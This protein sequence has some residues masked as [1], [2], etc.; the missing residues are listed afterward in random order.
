MM[1]SLFG[2][3]KNS[4]VRYALGIFALMGLLGLAACQRDPFY[5]TQDPQYQPT[6]EV[7]TIRMDTLL[8]RRS[9]AT[10]LLTVYNQ[11]NQNLLLNKVYTQKGTQEGYRINVDGRAGE[12]HTDILLPAR[13]SLYIR[14]EAT[15]P[16][17]ESDLPT[18]VRDSLLI[19]CQG[20]RSGALLLGFRQNVTELKGERITQNRTLTAQRPYRVIDSLIVEEGATLT[21]EAGV[22]LLVDARAYIRVRGTLLSQGTPQKRVT[23]EGSRLDRLLPTVSY[24]WIP[25]QWQGMV[26]D[27]PSQNNRWSYTTIRNAQQGVY[28]YPD[29]REKSAKLSMKGCVI[30][31]MNRT[32]LHTEGGVF[33]LENCELSNSG[34]ALVDCTAGELSLH[35][36]TLVN[37]FPWS[38][39]TQ[40]AV[41]LRE[42][43]PM[44]TR[45]QAT[46]TIVDGNRTQAA[47]PKSIGGEE[48]SIP[49]SLQEKVLWQE[50]YLRSQIE[51]HPR[52]FVSCRR[53][54]GTARDRYRL[55][56]WDSKNEKSSFLYDFRPLLKT[57]LAEW[58]LLNQASATDLLGVVRAPSPTI[59]AYQAV[60]PQVPAP[61]WILPL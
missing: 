49:E 46:R 8:S 59:G 25:G 43:A 48:L 58:V 61:W 54:E 2:S 36:C 56:G 29:P 47:P 41:V 24:Q 15:Y 44:P 11:T 33:E 7:D 53:A 39:R 55:T 17:G 50:C 20:R 9:S 35:Y 22:R 16:E 26:I 5:H 45:W 12:L 21:L 30:T 60:E 27:S 6:I 57:D 3:I 37:L 14:I 42:N 51:T 1:F 18:P 40:P 52:V 4:S 38:V 34:A 19:E 32:A 13:D 31:N 10:Y 28:C 23:I